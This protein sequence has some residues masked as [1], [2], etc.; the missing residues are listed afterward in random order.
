M[1]WHVDP[2]VVRL[3]KSF[4]GTAAARLVQ[5]MNECKVHIVEEEHVGLISAPHR[6]SSCLTELARRRLDQKNPFAMTTQ[7][8]CE[9]EHAKDALLTREQVELDQFAKATFAMNIKSLC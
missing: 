6:K 7:R 2:I 3:A 4:L 8:F 1:A 9:M 5:L